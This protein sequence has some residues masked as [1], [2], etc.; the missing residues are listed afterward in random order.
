MPESTSTLDQIRT[1]DRALWILDH[2]TNNNAERILAINQLLPSTPEVKQYITNSNLKE[3]DA[4]IAMGIVYYNIGNIAASE[5]C[6]QLKASCHTPAST[7]EN[8]SAPTMATYSQEDDLYNTRRWYGIRL[9][10]F[11]PTINKFNNVTEDEFKCPKQTKCSIV[12]LENINNALENQN[13]RRDLFIQFYNKTSPIFS[14]QEPLKLFILN[15]NYFIIACFVAGP[16][17][18]FVF[19][20]MKVIKRISGR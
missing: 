3:N 13:N 5:H 19:N 4:K 1:T 6:L 14:L 17:I 7:S 10:N 12:A 20:N 8:N 2:N 11:S 15:F 18:L 16:V 9:I